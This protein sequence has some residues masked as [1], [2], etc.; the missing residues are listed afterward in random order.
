MKTP[1]E[2]V[3]KKFE[4]ERVSNLR[5]ELFSG[6][7]FRFL[8]AGLGME[9]RRELSQELASEYNV[10]PVPLADLLC[11]WADKL[12]TLERLDD[13]AWR[14]ACGLGPL[15]KGDSLANSFL[16]GAYWVPALIWDVWPANVSK[17]G[18]SQ[19]AVEVRVLGD[20]YGGLRLYNKIAFKYVKYCLTSLL[21]CARFDKK[22]AVD[23]VQFRTA[24]KIDATGT[25]PRVVEFFCPSGALSRNRKLYKSRQKKP[26]AA[27]YRLT[28][29]ECTK[30]FLGEKGCPFAVRPVDYVQGEC[31]SCHAQGWFSPRRLKEGD[32]CVACE[33]RKLR[34]EERRHVAS[35]VIGN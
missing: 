6:T 14:I 27:G 29:A 30:G 13:I 9:E 15:R 16:T 18:K 11:P 28:C 31:K 12:I 2:L 26:C 10:N 22:R 7:L 21:G 35:A 1:L 33:N 5:D 17:S 32:P 3:G 4:F 8:G 23:I 25:W 19:V 20:T 34:R 24:V